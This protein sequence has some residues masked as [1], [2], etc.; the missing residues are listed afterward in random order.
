[1]QQITALTK[2]Q[3]E[4]LLFWTVLRALSPGLSYGETLLSSGALTCWMVMLEVLLLLVTVL[5]LLVL[6]LS[7]RTFAFSMLSWLM[8]SETLVTLSAADVDAH[9]RARHVAQCLS[10]VVYTSDA[11][12]R[13]GVQLE[14]QMADPRLFH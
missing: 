2:M 3:H 7:L 11:V 10:A 14:S 9:S 4:A 1:M 8:T 6:L 13:C 12:T 5:V